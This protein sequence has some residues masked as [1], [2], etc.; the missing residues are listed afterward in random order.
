MLGSG[1]WKRRCSGFQVQGRLRLGLELVQWQCLS[2]LQNITIF[3]LFAIVTCRLIL[4]QRTA[5]LST[6]FLLIYS[7]MFY[8]FETESGD[9][10]CGSGN[11]LKVRSQ[12]T[13]FSL[14]HSSPRASFPLL[15]HFA[16][17]C[18]DE[19]TVYASHKT[20]KSRTGFQLKKVLSP[21]PKEYSRDLRCLTSHCALLPL[22]TSESTTCFIAWLPWDCAAFFE[23]LYWT[24][25]LLWH[26]TITSF[27]MLKL[28]LLATATAFAMVSVH[29]QSTSTLTVPQSAITPQSPS[30]S[31]DSSSFD[32]VTVTESGAVGDFSSTEVIIPVWVL[33]SG[34]E[35]LFISTTYWIARNRRS[36]RPSLRVSSHPQDRTR[37]QPR[38]SSEHSKPSLLR[39]HSHVVHAAPKQVIFLSAQSVSC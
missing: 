25:Q 17:Y 30:S 29:A 14:A 18:D 1:F 3:I 4:Q 8:C 27:T 11:L 26:S 16:I 10:T 21:T 38:R 32:S 33:R 7:P 39:C 37:W 24:R 19:T 31:F 35:K 15:P 36:P 9:T 23:E 6:K 13:Y 12:N 2:C 28:S 22:Q 20:Q 34:R 5:R